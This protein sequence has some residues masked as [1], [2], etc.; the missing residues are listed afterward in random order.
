[1][2]CSHNFLSIY[3]HIIYLVTVFYISFIC[4]F[5]DLGEAE[6]VMRRLKCKPWS[7]LLVHVV[8]A[9]ALL[10]VAYCCEVIWIVCQNNKGIFKWWYHIWTSWIFLSSFFTSAVLLWPKRNYNISP[11]TSQELLIPHNHTPH[12]TMTIKT[13]TTFCV[14][15]SANILQIQERCIF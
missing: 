14:S 12:F 1:M 9:V 15:E 6:I 3:K 10:Q 5:G 2:K 7:W 8:R 11:C 4:I 13:A